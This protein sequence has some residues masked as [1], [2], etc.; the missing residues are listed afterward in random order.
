MCLDVRKSCEC[1]AHIVQFHLH[2]NIMLPEIID[3]LFCPTC[4]KETVFDET[5]M[6]DDNGWVIEYDIELA[7]DLAMK[8]L[9]IDPS[10]VV[11]AFIFDNDYA[12]WQEM[13]PGEQKD[14]KVEKEEIVKLLAE[15]QKKYLMAIHSW[16]VSR[17]E[18]LKEAGWRRAQTA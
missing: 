8:K 7:Q 14:I 17:I 5:T 18:Q 4:S 16:N 12:R 15:D 6:L 3:R 11:P 2:N 13:Y 9:M 1:G 10:Q